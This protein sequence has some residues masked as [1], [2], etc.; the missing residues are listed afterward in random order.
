MRFV[1]FMGILATIALPARATERMTVAQLEQVLAQATT[2]PHETKHNSRPGDEVSQISDSDLLQQLGSDDGILERLAGIELSERLS[3]PTL[4]RLVGKYSLGTEAQMALEA[5]AD[6]SA[7]LPLPVA[8]EPRLPVPDAK[9][10][11]VILKA[12][13]DYV[14]RRLSHLPD[15]VATRTTTTFDNTPAPLKFF[16]SMTDGGGFRKLGTE[17]RQ[18]TFQDGKEI[19]ESAAGL[20]MK[21]EGSF[22]SRGEFGTQAA[23]VVMDLEHGTVRFDHW[24][25][26]MGGIAAVFAYSVPRGSS[27]YEVTDSCKERRWF[28]DFPAFHGEIGLSPKTGA[29]LRITLEADWNPDDPVSHVASVVEYGPVVIGNRRSLCPLRSLAFL[30][31]EANGC[32]RTHR[33][34]QKPVKMINRTIFSNYH[35]FGSSSTM[36]FDEAVGQDAVPAGQPARSN[37]NKEKSSPIEPPAASLERAHP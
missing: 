35:R 2:K 13:R 19:V 24:E 12:A 36:I 31:Q 18:I 32:S 29:I 8:E 14:M 10:Q 22:E 28:Q 30:T 1:V 27:H 7:L 16:R 15:F 3:T 23:V 34:L 17:Q 4:Y 20:R 5:M 11:E 25:N 6:R 9:A 26:S 37:N 21:S 33:R